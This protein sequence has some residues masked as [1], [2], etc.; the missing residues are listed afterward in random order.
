MTRSPQTR[1]PQIRIELAPL[2]SI[3]VNLAQ[4]VFLVFVVLPVT[5][6]YALKVAPWAVDLWHGWDVIAGVVWFVVVWR[7]LSTLPNPR[8]WPPG[9]FDQE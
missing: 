3:N 7:F 1:K 9:E 5:L 4:R 2:L 8:W 6:W